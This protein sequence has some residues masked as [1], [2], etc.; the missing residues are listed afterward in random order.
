MT[1]K[2]DFVAD[3][4]TM[5]NVASIEKNGLTLIRG[6]GRKFLSEK[7]LS[8]DSYG[9]CEDNRTLM[10]SLTLAD[11]REVAP[12]ICPGEVITCT[13]LTRAA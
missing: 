7:I 3:V 2:P 11:D 12:S 8:I 6:G 10:V 1:P 5:N 13:E 9:V 4:L